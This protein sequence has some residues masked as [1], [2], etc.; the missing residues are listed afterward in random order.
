MEKTAYKISRFLTSSITALQAAIC[1][2]HLGHFNFGR[3]R[4][5]VLSPDLHHH[6]LPPVM[7]GPAGHDT[8]LV[9]ALRG[10]VLF[11]LHKDRFNLRVGPSFERE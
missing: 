10:A 6:D 8:H 3:R 9:P 1:A 11:V 4:Q 5:G 7:R 2:K